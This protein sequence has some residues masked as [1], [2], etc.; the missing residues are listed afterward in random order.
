MGH[1]RMLDYL[2]LLLMGLT[3]ISAYIAESAEP[4]LLVTLAHICQL[5]SKIDPNM[6]LTY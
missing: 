3:L 1:D 2:W 5:L 6:A 4:S